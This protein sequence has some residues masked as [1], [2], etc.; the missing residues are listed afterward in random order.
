MRIMERFLQSCVPLTGGNGRKSLILK[1]SL[2]ETRIEKGRYLL[3]TGVV[4]IIWIV[5]L[6]YV[7]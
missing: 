7:T 4:I 2:E 6:I 5:I 3:L 1:H